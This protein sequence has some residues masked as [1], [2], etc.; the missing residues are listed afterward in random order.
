MKRILLPPLTEM[1]NALFSL[2]KKD[3]Y[4]FPQMKKKTVLPL[5]KKKPFAID[6]KANIFP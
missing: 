6:G 4:F 2:D 1:K 5:T 3:N